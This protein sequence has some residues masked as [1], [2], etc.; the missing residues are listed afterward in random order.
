MDDKEIIYNFIEDNKGNLGKY[1]IIIN[2]FIT[3]IED[4]NKT[5]KDK[6]NNKI[7]GDTKISDIEIVTNL[8]N[9]SEDFKQLFQ[10]NQRNN[11]DKNY[12]NANL[13]VSK[14]TNIFDYFLKLIFRYVKEDIEKY[15]EKKSD[16]KLEDRDMAIKKED[17]ADAIRKFITLVLFREKDN[18]KEIKIKN[19]KKNIIDYLNNRYLWKSNLYNDSSKFE[20]NLLKLK[21]LNIKIKEILFFYYYLVGNKDEGFEN[22]IERHIQKKKEAER[23]RKE[24][25]EKIKMEEENKGKNENNLEEGEYIKKTI[26]K[27]TKTKKPPNRGD[28]EG[29]NKRKPPK[30]KNKD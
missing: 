19:N 11:Q 26:T 3:V 22:E 2:N 4:L 29:K 18:D 21:E 27:K 30:K 12:S 25:E 23:I 10:G 28:D 14:I 24:R 5:S 13:N 7:T 15:Q 20:A 8:N 16:Y 17:L 9:I 1:Q 6:N